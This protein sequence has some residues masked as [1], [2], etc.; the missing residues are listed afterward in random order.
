[1]AEKGTVF[2]IQ[3]FC[4]DDGPGIR[5]TVFLKGCPLNCMWCHNPESQRSN[6]EIFFDEE[7]CI[8]CGD[9]IKV[10]P[11]NCH[12]LKNGKHIFDRTNCK[13]CFSCTK[14]CMG[15][16]LTNIGKTITA[17]EVLEEVKKDLDFYKNSG[18]GITLSGGEPLSQ[19]DFS[20]SL[21][22]GAK[23]AGISTCI[24]TCGYVKTEI[25]KHFIKV[26][27]L[28]LFDFKESNN[29]KHRLFTGVGNELILKNLDMLDR[30]KANVILRCPI[31]P[32]FNDRKEHFKGIAELAD[33]KDCIKE[34]QIEPYHNLGAFKYTKLAKDYPASSAF[35]ADENTVNEWINAIAHYCKKPIK[36][37]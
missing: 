11:N 24:E 32:S 37:A 21:L 34:V 28:F 3:R 18:G 19:P 2:N 4:T 16:S 13:S 14:A 31:I 22:R 27:D 23:N 10:C 33:N 15:K 30:Y 26:T 36:K 35:V 12:I 7:K 6:S 9:C 1:M 20:L 17:K 5:T 29:E 25:L 8:S